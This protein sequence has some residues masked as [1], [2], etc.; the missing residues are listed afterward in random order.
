MHTVPDTGTLSG[1]SVL[2]DMHDANLPE[3][4]A[5]YGHCANTVDDVAKY[6]LLL[7]L[8]NL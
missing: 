8:G 4:P 1:K 2:I 3:K 5:L 6:K 7:T